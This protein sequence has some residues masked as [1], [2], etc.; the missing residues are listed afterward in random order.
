MNRFVPSVAIL[1]LALA[2]GA[3]GASAQ[4]YAKRGQGIRSATATQA[5]PRAAVVTT[6]PRAAV[7]ATPAPAAPRVASHDDR[8][9]GR[10]EDRRWGRHDD[11]HDNRRHKRRWYRWWW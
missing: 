7:V 2:V 5:A 4:T 10:H 3:A 8:G 1:G 11:H 9:W 6:A